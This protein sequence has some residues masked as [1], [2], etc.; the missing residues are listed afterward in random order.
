MLYI[1]G[2]CDGCEIELGKKKKK[3]KETKR[4]EEEEGMSRLI[5][6]H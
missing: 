1:W 6:L 4:M 3:K 2:M 5:I